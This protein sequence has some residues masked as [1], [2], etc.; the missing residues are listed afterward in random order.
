MPVRALRRAVALGCALV[1]AVPA[2]AAAAEGCAEPLPAIYER[3][4]P[5]VVLITAVSVTPNQLT[6][7][8]SRIVGSGVI[9]HR[10]GL[11]L[12]NAHVA[13]GRHIIT[14]T[15]DDGTSLPGT[16]VGAD[17]IFDLALVRLPAP[18]AGELPVARLGDSSRLRVGDE[19]LAL[20]HPLGLD[21]TLTRGV[22]SGLN[23]AFS[24]MPYAAAEPLIQTD[25]PINPGNSGGPL[26]DRCG[27]VVGITSAS[28]VEA[29]GIGFAIPVNVVKTVLPQLLAD[30]RVIRPWLGFQGQTVS[31][32]LRSLLRLP[33]VE[34]LLV[35]AVEPG[36]PAERA[37][38]RG[39]SLEVAVSGRS[40]LIGGDVVTAINGTRLGSD[41]DVA[42]VV[43][44][45]KV[46]DTVR[47][48]TVRDG[49]P[50]S[51]EYVLPER[52]VQ[53]GDLAGSRTGL[54]GRRG[55]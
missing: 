3:V 38:L 30:G 55:R 12:T 42:R 53:P 47:L 21:Q 16:L 33:L 15:L 23:R 50:R 34:G 26:V 35:E 52:P 9:V 7:R 36:S 25:T 11:V 37:G 48:T 1:A 13:W 41:E 17:P 2:A 51:V 29:Q 20:G 5:T 46:G 6:E 45:L 18:D 14:V 4:S 54:R 32:F 8:V 22:V 28:V 31:A 39:G 10:S 19:V 43:R 49:Q 27:T 24:E 44:Q 40:V